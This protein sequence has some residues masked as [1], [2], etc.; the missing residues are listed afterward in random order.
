[1]FTDGLLNHAVT[2]SS[3]VTST[4]SMISVRLWDEVAV[5]YFEILID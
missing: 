1:L 5:A 3:Y 4:D 2:S